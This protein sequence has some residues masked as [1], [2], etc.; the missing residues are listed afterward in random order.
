MLVAWSIAF[1]SIEVSSIGGMMTHVK[2]NTAMPVKSKSVK[3][4]SVCVLV[5]LQH[6]LSYNMGII[7]YFS[8]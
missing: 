1:T 8:R 5:K 2:L 4:K 7:L 6:I 3:S